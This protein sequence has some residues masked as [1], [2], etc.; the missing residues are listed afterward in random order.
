[1]KSRAI[2]TIRNTRRIKWLPR[3]VVAWALLLNLLYAFSG[4]ECLAGDRDLYTGRHRVMS[5]QIAVPSCDG[6]MIANEYCAKRSGDLPLQGD[7]FFDCFDQCEDDLGTISEWV[8][9]YSDSFM[10]DTGCVKTR[11]QPAFLQS[12][13]KPPQS[14]SSGKF[15]I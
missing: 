9:K 15:F 3:V 10:F 2:R 13:L 6:L 4:P 7:A 12:I 14:Q 1:M 11:P 5:I 8:N